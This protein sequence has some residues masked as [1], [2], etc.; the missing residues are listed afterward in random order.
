MRTT[1][2]NHNANTEHHRY[3]LVSAILPFS[4]GHQMEKKTL[5][6]LGTKGCDEPNTSF[7]F[8]NES[9]EEN[10]WYCWA[11]VS[12]MLLLANML[13]TC[14]D[15]TFLFGVNLVIIF[16]LI[17]P[18]FF[19]I[20]V[21]QLFTGSCWSVS[22]FRRAFEYCN[23]CIVQTSTYLAFL[24]GSSI[25][26]FLFNRIN[27]SKQYVVYSRCIPFYNRNTTFI[28]RIHISIIWIYTKCCVL[29]SGRLSISPAWQHG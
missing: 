19:M 22:F 3:I 9:Q 18:P 8:L 23:V 16:V 2:C 10:Q 28:F 4:K 15:T 13:V 26:S 29:T 7:V 27:V 20:S 11:F 25:H 17:L 24:Q 1:W 21:Q 6:V 5:V 12:F 14:E